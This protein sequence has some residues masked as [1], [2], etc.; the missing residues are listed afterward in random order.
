MAVNSI[1]GCFFV[2]T[3]RNRAIHCSEGYLTQLADPLTDPLNHGC[4]TNLQCASLI[5]G[6]VVERSLNPRADV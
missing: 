5:F 6:M 4:D 2:L 3:T 1:S